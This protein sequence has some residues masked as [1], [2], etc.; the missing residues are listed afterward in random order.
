MTVSEPQQLWGVPSVQMDRISIDLSQVVGQR[1]TV[2]VRG[3]RNGRR[4]PLVLAVSVDEGQ[5]V[6][7]VVGMLAPLLHQAWRVP[8]SWTALATAAATRLG[9]QGYEVSLR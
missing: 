8:K 4:D 5:N 6:G 1:S 7:T 3:W 9:R 2:I